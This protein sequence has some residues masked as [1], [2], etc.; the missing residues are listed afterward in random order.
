MRQTAGGGQRE[1]KL[2]AKTTTPRRPWAAHGLRL[3]TPTAGQSGGLN[4]GALCP[5]EARADARARRGPSCPAVCTCP[6]TMIGTWCLSGTASLRRLRPAVAPRRSSDEGGPRVPPPALRCQLSEA[7]R[8]CPR[9]REPAGLR[10]TVGAAVSPPRTPGLTGGP[11]RQLGEGAWRAPVHLPPPCPEGTL[12]P[13][14][15]AGALPARPEW[16]RRPCGPVRSGP[17]R[18]AVGAGREALAQR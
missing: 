16:A 17:V 18:S 5:R 7:A 12:A 14:S 1:Q 13:R 3:R 15:R 9:P 2:C 4:P 8:R 11:P 6:V 10:E